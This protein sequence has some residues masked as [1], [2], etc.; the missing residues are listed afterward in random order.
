MF[1]NE[2]GVLITVLDNK[3][4]RLQGRGKIRKS[5]K[6]ISQHDIETL[7]A[8]LLLQS[9]IQKDFLSLRKYVSDACTDSGSRGEGVSKGMELYGLGGTVISRLFEAENGN[10]VVALRRGYRDH[11]SFPTLKSLQG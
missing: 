9:P 7:Y 3:I 5:H 4:K 8:S 6:I 1:E 11:R 2:C 10:A